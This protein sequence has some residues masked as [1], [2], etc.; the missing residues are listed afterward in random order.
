MNV[1]SVG[2]L[3]IIKIGACEIC[4]NP[5]GQ[6]EIYMH[7][8]DLANKQYIFCGDIGNA[9]YSFSLLPLYLENPKINDLQWCRKWCSEYYK[10]LNREDWKKTS[11]V[12]NKHD[13]NMI[14]SMLGYN[15]NSGDVICSNCGK[16]VSDW[17]FATRYLC[18]D[19][20]KHEHG[21]S[22]KY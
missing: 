2:G 21:V 1:S 10:S 20:A 5:F 7:V 17:W 11:L 9:G 18:S 12:L 14:F 4:H 22:N 16:K 15:G 8:M 3:K 13:F 6:S 19:C